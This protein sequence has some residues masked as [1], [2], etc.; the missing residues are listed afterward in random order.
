M[1]VCVSW[2]KER[3]GWNVNGQAVKR[4]WGWGWRGNARGKRVEGKEGRG[5]KG[6][7]EL[8]N[9]VQSN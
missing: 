3:G 2:G 1:C 9:I 4:G 8:V 5:V 7:I 6:E